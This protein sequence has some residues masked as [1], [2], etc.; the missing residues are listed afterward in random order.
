MQYVVKSLIML[1]SLGTA[2]NVLR[3]II[4]HVL[5]SF[6][7]AAE[8]HMTTMTKAASLL[9]AAPFI[10]L[11]AD[12]RATMDKAFARAQSEGLTPAEQHDADVALMVARTIVNIAYEGIYAARREYDDAVRNETITMAQAEALTLG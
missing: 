1:A 4:E 6:L 8:Y 12:A 3:S 10:A 2:K 9:V 7:N 11:M 5:M